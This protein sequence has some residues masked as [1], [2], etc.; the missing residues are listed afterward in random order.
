MLLFVS[1][2]STSPEV[3]SMLLEENNLHRLIKILLFVNLGIQLH[4]Y[5]YIWGEKKRYI[6]FS[7]SI[8]DRSKGKL[9]NCTLV[10]AFIWIFY[11]I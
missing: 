5:I 8:P 1:H 6:F 4:I 10:G 7:N 3:I 11:R 9:M 2:Y